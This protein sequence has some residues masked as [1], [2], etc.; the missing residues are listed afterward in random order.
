MET[1]RATVERIRSLEVKGARNVA[2]AA[3]EALQALAKETKAKNREEFLGELTEALEV[4]RPVDTVLANLHPEL[5]PNA[6]PP[7][8]P[9]HPPMAGPEPHLLLAWAGH[10]VK[11]KVERVSAGNG[12]HMGR[13]RQPQAQP[14]AC[15]YAT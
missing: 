9:L 12:R 5:P 1:V 11:E 8:H 6:P 4:A 13:R 14:S 2:M 3:V 15:R 7:G 10:R